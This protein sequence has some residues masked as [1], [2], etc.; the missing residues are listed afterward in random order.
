M[1]TSLRRALVVLVA[2]AMLVACG[3]GDDD[4]TAGTTTG[5]GTAVDAL[6]PAVTGAAMEQPPRVTAESGVLDLRLVASGDTI[7][8]AGADV[9]GQAYDG[10]FVGPT[11]V[12][13]PGDRIR[14]TFENR[15]DA[16][17][18]IHFH[19]LHVSPANNGDNIFLSIDAGETF[20]YALDIPTDHNPGTFWYHSHA[21][22]ISEEQVFGG[23]S[24]LIVVEGLADLL[25]EHLR[26]VADVA[27]ALKD[28]QVVGDRI[29]TADIDS[30]APTLRT[31]NAQHVP[32]HRIASGETQLWRLAN[33]GADI[34]YDVELDDHTLHVVG[35]DGNPVWEVW[36]A[37]H[38]VLPP[39]K[40]YD[41]L[42][43]GG[44]ESQYTLRTRRYDQQG[45]VYPQRPLATV[46]VSGAAADPP[47]LPTS[48][49]RAAPVPA[50]AVSGRRT[51]VF[52]EDD[53]AGD[54][55]IDDRKFDAD[56]VDVEVA[57]DATEE[58]T[59]RN[60]TTEQHPFHIH[61]NDFQVVSVAGEPYDA[62]S[63]QDTVTLPPGEDVVIRMRFTDFTG[64]FVFHCHIL[65]HEDNGMMAVVE[66]R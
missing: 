23:L 57:L 61:V 34:W 18:N 54:F 20:E 5:N 25:P 12:V 53:A 8:V 28:T 22:G 60:S 51:F 56:R 14:L 35:E 58:W 44:A 45:D 48:L 49:V 33:I 41:V 26:D 16:H 27:F 65:N 11:L 30:N 7:E 66:V 17:T 1:A 43:T 46:E 29:E 32:V 52:T 37:A 21:H 38:L 13:A 39:G 36:E 40:R 2:G 24:G 59:I 19:G 4:G 42:V 31:V 64:R 15:L 55:Y 62:R 10:G 9:A 6:D 3:D 50:G 47:P 63:L